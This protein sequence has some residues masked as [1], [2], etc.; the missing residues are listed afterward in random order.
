MP[1]YENNNVRGTLVITFDIAFPKGELKAV[2][3]EGMYTCLL[4]PS[5]MVLGLWVFSRLPLTG[6]VDILSFFYAKVE[7]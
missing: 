2:D 5:F 6:Y 3:K 1:N 7:V 4:D